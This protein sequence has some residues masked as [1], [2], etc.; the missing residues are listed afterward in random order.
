L[1]SFQQLALI[2]DARLAVVERAE[3]EV[4]LPVDAQTEVVV[5]VADE[6]CAVTSGLTSCTRS[7]ATSAL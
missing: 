7:A 2:A 4:H 1:P 6:A 3:D 5:D